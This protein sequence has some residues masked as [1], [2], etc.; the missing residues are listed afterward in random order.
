M[1]KLILLSLFSLL[2]CM[3]NVFAQNV[4][5]TSDV[6]IKKSGKTG[7]VIYVHGGE[8]LPKS[9]F[10]LERNQET[11]LENTNIEN[12]NIVF[13][14]KSLMLTS[15]GVTTVFALQDERQFRNNDKDIFLGYGLGLS[16]NRQVLDI[17]DESLTDPTFPDIFGLTCG[18][19]L[20]GSNTPCK[21][22][23]TGSTE[24]SI[25]DSTYAGVSGGGCSVSCGSGYYA[26]CNQ[27]K[28]SETGGAKH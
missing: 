19:A 13:H 7:I 25:S 9:Y 4:R 5:G 18:C 15:K 14:G 11:Q 26:C 23:G 12:C 16:T 2:T 20:N 6:T 10:F 8:E 28:I 1:K 3:T 17:L 24:C 22:G 21:D 27:M